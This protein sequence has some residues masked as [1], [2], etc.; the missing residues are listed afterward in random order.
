MIS[1]RSRRREKKNW[2]NMIKKNEEV[3]KKNLKMKK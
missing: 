3:T 1:N 2:V